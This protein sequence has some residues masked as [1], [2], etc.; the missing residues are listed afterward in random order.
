MSLTH[1]YHEL[2]EMIPNMKTHNKAT[3]RPLNIQ[4]STFDKDHYLRGECYTLRF[5]EP[6][7]DLI[8]CSMGADAETCEAMANTVNDALNNYDRLREVETAARNARRALGRLTHADLHRELEGIK[9]KL[10]T[11]LAATPE[12][13]RQEAQRQREY[14]QALEAVAEAGRKMLENYRELKS[15]SLAMA[16]SDAPGWIGNSLTVDDDI[17][18]RDVTKA[19]DNLEAIRKDKP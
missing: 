8:V 6:S 18:V 11:A 15:I 19:L 9:S 10:S 4:K 14:V 5:G 13:A 2:L 16:K 1:E 7:I 17:H 12:A 3:P